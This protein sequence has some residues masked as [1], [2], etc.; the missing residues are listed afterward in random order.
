MSFKELMLLS[1]LTVLLGISLVYALS[2]EYKPKNSTQTFPTAEGVNEQFGLKLTMTLEKTDYS[3]GEPINI[4]MTLTNIGNQ[5]IDL[6]WEARTF[7][8]R[9]YNVTD[10]GIYQWSSFRVFPC[11]VVYMPIDP[12]T[13]LTNVLVWPQTCNR[14]VDSLLYG[15]EGV[16]VS[17]G[18]YF[19]VGQIG[20][21]YELQTTPIQITIVKP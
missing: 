19:I 15:V 3:L 6:L 20:Y 5:T 4:T 12:G 2:Y 10:N 11:H 18:T 9:V 14:T 1:A 21:A 13:G 16:P 7:D 17:P 8:F